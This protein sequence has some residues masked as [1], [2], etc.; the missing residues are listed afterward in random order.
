VVEWLTPLL[1]VR[2]VPGSNLGSETDYPDGGSPWYLQTNAGI[3]S[4]KA[5]AVPL[6]DTKELGW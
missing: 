5:K 4:Y 1:R 3:K 2:E 6:H